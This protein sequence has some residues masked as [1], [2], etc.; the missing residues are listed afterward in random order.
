MH[1][2]SHKKKSSY[3]LFELV[4]GGSVINGAMTGDHVNMQLFL[5]D[6]LE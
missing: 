2:M 4:G 5:K 1:H 6:K 3:K